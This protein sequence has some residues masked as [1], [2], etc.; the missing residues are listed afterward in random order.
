MMVWVVLQVLWPVIRELYLGN[1]A[2]DTGLYKRLGGPQR[3]SKR[4]SEEINKWLSI[5]NN[6]KYNVRDDD[7]SNYE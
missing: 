4:V 7:N 2:P 5:T 3:L 1:R 6:N